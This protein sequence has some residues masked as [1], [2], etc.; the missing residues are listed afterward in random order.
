MKR[1]HG[2]DGSSYT[3]VILSN[4]SF[5]FA[6]L[7]IERGFDVFA[8]TMHPDTWRVK[9]GWKMVLGFALDP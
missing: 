2:I 1:V 3:L 5:H 4:C 7:V 8:T 6:A 9:S